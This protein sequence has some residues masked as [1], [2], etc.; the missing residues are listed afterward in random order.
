LTDVRS[1][2]ANDIRAECLTCSINDQGI[3]NSNSLLSPLL[4]LLLLLQAAV[5]H[6]SM[7]LVGCCFLMGVHCMAGDSIVTG[8]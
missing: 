2:A 4:L 6:V 5:C 1:L 8:Y 3:S 7:S